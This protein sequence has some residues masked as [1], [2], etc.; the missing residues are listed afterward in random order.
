MK[1]LLALLVLAAT[2]AYSQTFEAS[3]FFG[4]TNGKTIDTTTR[5]VDDLQIDGGFTYGVSGTYFITHQLG[6]EGLFA[7]QP[8]SVSMTVAGVT[9]PVFDMKVSQVFGNIVF[10]PLAR[11]AMFRP[12]VFGGLGTTIM[13]AQDI[14]SSSHFAWDIGGGLKWAFSPVVG[15]RFHVRYSGTRLNDA[16]STICAPFGFCE[17]ALPRFELAGG[18]VLRF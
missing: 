10:E 14:D 3:A 18:V 9:A 15:A 13:T 17:D 2:P 1:W 8:T 11:T 12:F 6:V 5:N 4:T 7:Q 16:G